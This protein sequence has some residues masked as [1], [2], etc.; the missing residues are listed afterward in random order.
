[1]DTLEK[2]VVAEYM[3]KI[4]HNYENIRG[5]PKDS[6]Q[7]PFWDIVV[8]TAADADQKIAFEAQ[9]QQKLQNKELPLDLPIY[10]VAD[11]PGPKLGNGGSTFSA[12]DFLN[13]KYGSKLFD[14]H[15]LLIHAGGQS[16]RLPSASVLGK[17]FSAVPHGEPVYQMLDIKLA[18][19]WPLL[20]RMSPG[21]F[22]ACADDFLVYNMENEDDW[23][24]SKT[25]FTALAHP[26]SVQIGTKHGVYVCENIDKVD[27]RK[28][29][30][31]ARAL[32]VLQKPSAEKMYKKNAVL[33]NNSDNLKSGVLNSCKSNIVYTDS[34]FFF[35]TDIMQRFL[36]FLEGNGPVTCE[37]DAYGDFLQALGPKATVDY[38][39]NTSNIS[40]V[41]PNLIATREKIFNLLKGTEID[42][43]L[44]NSSRFIHIGSTREY[45]YHFCADQ[46]F[47]KQL[48]LRKDIF[49]Q[50]TEQE[51]DG[52][53]NEKKARFSDVSEGCVL[54]SIL[55][56]EAFVSDLSIMEYCHFDVPVS[57]AQDVIISNCQFLSEEVPFEK[58]KLEIPNSV[59][60]HS[61]PVC[62][63]EITKYVTIYFHIDDSLKK[64]V[65]LK[66]AGGLPF[67]GKTLTDVLQILHLELSTVVPADYNRETLSLWHA[68][69]Y[70]VVDSMSE[71]LDVTLK[72]ISAIKKETH[73]AHDMSKYKLVS[74]DECLKT[75]SLKTMLNYRQKLFQKIIQ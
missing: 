37:I 6:G 74:I 20:S 39:H 47:Q 49:N 15:T 14:L 5:K 38:I 56:K 50:W 29:I 26:S 30:C 36:S 42:I 59:F 41:D 21:V 43:L 40:N 18:M 12:L 55:P 23:S 46:T 35:G 25:G 73:G 69:L 52:V 65:A 1:M 28:N 68:K 31:M 4:L 51:L 34:A 53:S 72:F 64:T 3:L 58:Q 2:D 48:S 45:I 32:E 10:V 57:V 67:M 9:V 8:I 11:P 7:S 70:P 27:S 24:F 61:I 17:I 44:M 19:Y 63:G 54:H 66:D 71:S 75:K 62:I 22:V 16:Q 60:L 13:K 33:K